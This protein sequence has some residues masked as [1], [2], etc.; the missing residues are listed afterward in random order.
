MYTPDVE[1]NQVRHRVSVGRTPK[2]VFDGI[3]FPSDSARKQHATGLGVDVRRI[4]GGLIRS[5]ANLF[6]AYARIAIEDYFA[7]RFTLLS[8]GGWCDK[9]FR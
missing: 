2:L 4:Q 3:G 1:S 5:V 9:S 8:N 7:V 6:E